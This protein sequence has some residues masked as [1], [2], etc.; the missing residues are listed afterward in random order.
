MIYL[1]WTSLETQL[2]SEKGVGRSHSQ[3]WSKAS[4]VRRR[5]MVQAEVYTE[6]NQRKARTTG[7]WKQRV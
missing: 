7:L 4:A 3:Q 2:K 6:E 5:T 1:Y